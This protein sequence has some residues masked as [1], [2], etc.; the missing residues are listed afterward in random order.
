[1]MTLE[2]DTNLEVGELIDYLVLCSL[3][4]TL[5]VFEVPNTS[6]PHFSNDVE[7]EAKKVKRIIKALKQVIKLY[8]IPNRNDNT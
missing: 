1:M 8:W 6:I 7:K 4:E 5:K 3:K 2:I